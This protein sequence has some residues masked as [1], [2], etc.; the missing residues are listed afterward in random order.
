MTDSGHRRRS[1]PDHGLN[2]LFVFGIDFVAVLGS[3]QHGCESER[4]V[5]QASSVTLDDRGRQ[6]R[7]HV[8]N[9]NGGEKAQCPCGGRK[10]GHT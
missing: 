9:M 3:H 6:D 4:R 1:V 10:A 5:L 8:C 2:L 7:H